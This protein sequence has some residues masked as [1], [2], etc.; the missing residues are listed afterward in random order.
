MMT[1][2]SYWRAY[3]ILFAG[4][5]ITLLIGHYAISGLIILLHLA[6]FILNKNVGE[7]IPNLVIHGVVSFIAISLIAATKILGFIDDAA[8]ALLIVFF[9]FYFFPLELKIKKLKL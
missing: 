9:I 5:G 8:F 6:L 1:V 3:V 4:Y 7:K 2:N